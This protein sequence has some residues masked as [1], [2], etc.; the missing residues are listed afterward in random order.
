MRF[1]VIGCG[2]VA[3]Y[4]HIPALAE[5][6]ETSL[7]ALS[8]LNGPRLKELG[9][10]HGVSR[11]Y[12]DYRELLA[13]E[14]IDAVT[15]AT[16]VTSHFAIAMDAVAAG[17]HVFC[18]K[19]ITDTVERGWQLVKAAEDANRLLA[20]NFE[21]RA[22]AAHRLIKKAI[23]AGEIGNVR[24]LRL[25]YNWSGP[26]WAGIERHRLLMTEGKGPI[27]DCGVHFFDLARWFSQSEYSQVMANG[28][29]MEE[30]PYPDHVVATCRMA[31][32]AVAVIDE[33]WVFGHTVTSSE[34]YHIN[35]IDIE[36]DNGT[37]F[38]EHLPGGKLRLV[39]QS[40]K[41]VR[42]EDIGYRKAFAEMYNLFLASIA[43]GHLIDLASGR[44]GVRAIEAANAALTS[45]AEGGARQKIDG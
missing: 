29:F 14:D 28:L 43:K 8:D 23:D 24:F 31:N 19:P 39:V 30:Y 15:I 45:V 32:G 2:T 20:V 41:G 1:G 44:D 40:P 12:T 37:A 3:G 21:L 9:A 25:V 18:E 33:S 22:D 38:L 35:R 36:G 6:P 13:Q 27:F 26:R 42:R 16:P 7:V 10:K 11:L 34:R 4:G 5:H 17:K